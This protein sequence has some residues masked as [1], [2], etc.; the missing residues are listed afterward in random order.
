MLNLIPNY[1]SKKKGEITKS[2]MDH[3]IEEIN[4]INNELH[5]EL[6]IK[7]SVK[8]S[9]QSEDN[10]HLKKIDSQFKGVL[11][12]KSQLYFLEF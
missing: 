5:E 9:K 2:R 3:K 10:K 12:L 6:N 4:R 8:V 7:C 11:S 1:A